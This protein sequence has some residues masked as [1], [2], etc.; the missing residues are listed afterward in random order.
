MVRIWLFG[1]LSVATDSCGG[2]VTPLSGRCGSLLAYLALRRGQYFSRSDLLG[3]LWSEGSAPMSAGSF[4]T[5]LWRLRRTIE[6]PPIKHGDLI[7]SD[8]RGGIGLS[9][10]NAIWLDIEEFER[11]IAPGLERSIEQLSDA[12]IEG[13]RIGVDLY[14]TDILSEFTDDWALREREKRRRHY[15]NA[16][17]RL[18][19]VETVRREYRSGI[20]YAQRILECD[21][22]RE[23]VHRELMRLFVLGGQRAQALRQFECCRETLRREL[24]IQPMRETLELYR[25]I[26]DSA[27]G[28]HRDSSIQL[29]IEASVGLV[30]D[31]SCAAG[32]GGDPAQRVIAMARRHLAAAD[33]QLEKLLRE[34]S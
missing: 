18:M 17:W 3:I 1:S 9:G 31:S 5:A 29:P 7:T 26:A 15:L 4:N 25:R 34:L 28:G 16:L 22:L 11:C 32:V 8:R 20:G 30:A 23:D 6:R 12:D 33:H 10:S 13:L 14:K 21:E 19:Q 2:E 24:A 27:I